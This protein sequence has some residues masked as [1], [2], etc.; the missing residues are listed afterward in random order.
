MTLAT[1]CCL[2]AL[3]SSTS[4]DGAWVLWS[5]SKVNGQTTYT[6]IDSFS[7]NVSG[8][9]QVICARWA[10]TFGGKPEFK[11]MTFICLPDTGDP[12]GPKV[13]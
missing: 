1:L 13:K 7:R 5:Q 11:E 10:K 3:V 9:P 8:R 12:R 4:A 2:L 6:R